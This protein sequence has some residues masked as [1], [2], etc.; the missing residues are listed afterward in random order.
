MAALLGLDFAEAH[1]VAEQAAAGQVC[2][3]ANDNGAGQVVVSG[4]RAAV[5]RAVELAKVRG[6]KRAVVLPVSAPFHCE[7]MRPAAEAMAA[8]LAAVTIRQPVPPL[9][10]NVTAS[11]VSD[12][13]EIARCLVAQVTGTVRWRECVA[14]MAE[15]GVTHFCEI[16]AGR[17]LSSLVRRIAEGASATAL[18]TPQDIEAFKASARA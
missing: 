2:Q 3:A 11:A 8:A 18:G 10:A 1:D 12:P 6:A 7:L 14:Y 9:V 16:G 5:E 13:A 15:R 4:H 17:V